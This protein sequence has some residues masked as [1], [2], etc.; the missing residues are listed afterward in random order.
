MS[1]QR[2]GRSVC[3]ALLAL[4]F[5]APSSS[6]GVLIDFDSQ[7]LFGPST[8]GEAGPA[9]TL[10]I[11]T[12]VGVVTFQGGVI[13]TAV[14]GNSNSSSVYETGGP[15]LS[16]TNPLV[17]SLPVPVTSFSLLVANDETFT[18]TYVVA[19]S[20]GHS[21]SNAVPLH[22]S[23]APSFP[24]V[25][26]M[27]VV[28]ALNTPSIPPSPNPDPW[29]FSIDNISFAA[30]PEPSTLCLLIAGLAGLFFFRRKG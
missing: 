11:T 26:T 14:D 15:G 10:S 28:T 19:D 12:S 8:L 24:S 2:L 20:A 4:W 27:I 13:L 3:V 30:I 6:R 1:K 7:G 17:I 25:G 22:S 16:Y 21:Q 18:I 29:S 23:W 5:L 9:Q